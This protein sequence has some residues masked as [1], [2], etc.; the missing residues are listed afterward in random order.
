MKTLQWIIENKSILNINRIEKDLGMAQGILSKAIG[1]RQ[2]LPKKWEKVLDQYFIPK[3][4]L[5][6]QPNP[7]S[8][9]PYN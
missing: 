2:K 5:I 3:I 4:Q 1:G 8:K 9:S 7:L 6:N